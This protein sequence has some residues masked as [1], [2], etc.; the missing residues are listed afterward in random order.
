MLT[1]QEAADFLGCSRPTLVRLLTDG[2]IPYEM[3]GRH[4]RVRLTDVLDYQHHARTERAETLDEMAER[5][6]R[7]SP[8]DAA[9]GPPPRTG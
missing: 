4:R 2:R 6:Q 1:T 7:D 8:Y 9:A 3:R 5:G